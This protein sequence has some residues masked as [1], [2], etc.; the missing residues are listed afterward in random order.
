M[1]EK[2]PFTPYMTCQKMEK[3][4]CREN[5]MKHQINKTRIVHIKDNEK[6][7]TKAGN[8]K[9]YKLKSMFNDIDKCSAKRWTW[10]E[11]KKN[12]FDKIDKK[13]FTLDLK[14]G[15]KEFGNYIVIE[16]HNQQIYIVLYDVVLFVCFAGM[17]CCWS[18]S[19]Y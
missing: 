17:K 5:F 19:G 12:P 13:V 15:N 18:D 3:K 10:D 9:T 8:D 1:C 4:R 6:W 14:R 16:H 7:G 2:I 11:F